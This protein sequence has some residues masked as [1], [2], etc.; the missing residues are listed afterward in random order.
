L[1]WECPAMRFLSGFVRDG[2]DGKRGV[3]GRGTGK[4]KDLEGFLVFR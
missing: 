3:I 4:I 2:F 1:N